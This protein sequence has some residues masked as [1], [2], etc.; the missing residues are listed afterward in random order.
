M[1]RNLDDGRVEVIAE[2]SEK[3]VNNFRLDLAT[4]PAHSRVTGVEEIV[5]DPTGAYPTFRI[6]R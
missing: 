2:G 4:G 6:D 5:I 1:V 3:A